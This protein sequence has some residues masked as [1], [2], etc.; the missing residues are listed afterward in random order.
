[1]VHPYL[2]Y[3][4]GCG[5][6]VSKNGESLQPRR[7][8]SK[9]HKSL[10]SRCSCNRTPDTD[11]RTPDTAPCDKAVAR[12]QE[13]KALVEHEDK[14]G[15]NRLLKKSFLKGEGNTAAKAVSS[16]EHFAA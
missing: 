3:K 14:P 13:I 5:A 8:A 15:L 6:K 16:L 2:S 4:Y 12:G 10:A 11:E 9:R 1:M 7:K